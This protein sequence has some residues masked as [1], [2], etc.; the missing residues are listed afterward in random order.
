MHVSHRDRSDLDEAGHGGEE[1]SRPQVPA[2]APAVLQSGE[3]FRGARSAA[4]GRPDGSG[5][6][7]TGQADPIEAA[8]RCPRS[9]P[10]ASQS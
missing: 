8:A 9:T 3:L 10:Q 2:R 7:R 6:R 5:R 4:P 1:P